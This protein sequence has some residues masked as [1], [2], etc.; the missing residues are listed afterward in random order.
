MDPLLDPHQRKGRAFV[1]FRVIE[2]YQVTVLL[3]VPLPTG[4]FL[5]NNIDSIPTMV[6]LD[7][8]IIMRITIIHRK[9][10]FGCGT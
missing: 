3:L 5:V 4:D 9:C 1:S 2:Y 7:N 6:I 10:Y 8:I